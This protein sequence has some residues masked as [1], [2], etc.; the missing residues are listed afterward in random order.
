MDETSSGKTAAAAPDDDGAPA[1]PASHAGADAR[2][3][4]RIVEDAVAP[5]DEA[6]P[7]MLIRRLQQQVQ[8]LQARIDGMT[9]AYAERNR[10]MAADLDL[11]ARTI[12]HDLRNQVAA[13]HGFVQ[14]LT[15]TQ[16]HDMDQEAREC[17]TWI[18]RGTAQ[19]SLML[20]SLHELLRIEFREPRIER[21]ELTTMAQDITRHLA[22]THA[23]RTVRVS[24]ADLPDAMGDPQLLRSALQHLLD[25][26]W[27]FT[28]RT[29]D[30]RIEVG[31]S[32]D[33]AGVVTY[34]V[35]DNG[36]GF[37]AGEM[38]K[39]FLP[40]KRMSTAEGMP[41]AG[42]GLALVRRVVEKHH[43]RVWTE[44]NPGGGASFYFTLGSDPA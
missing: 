38:A 33:A 34:H 41:G 42:I 12:S 2:S 32:R 16:S 13:I 10:R 36:I 11:C 29:Q 22:R 39:A 21:V 44:I 9:A 43:G 23:G 40:F 37:P 31:S 28:A 19:L 17:L 20:D 6:A 15:E 8:E 35:R 4:S 24:I 18:G 14:L 5:T 25:N 30:A 27:K 26:A 3:V 7:Q 1:T